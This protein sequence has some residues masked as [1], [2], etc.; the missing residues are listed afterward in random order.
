MLKSRTTP[1]CLIFAVLTVVLLSLSSTALAKTA[2]HGLTPKALT[3]Q[4]VGTL[5]GKAVTIGVPCTETVQESSS[6][7]PVCSL[8]GSRHGHRV[9]VV[10][11]CDVPITPVLTSTH[12]TN[13]GTKGTGI[14][15][16]NCKDK[17]AALV[18]PA[19]GLILCASDDS[20]TCNHN[21][22]LTLTPQGDPT[23]LAIDTS[24]S[25]TQPRCHIPSGT[26]VGPD[27]QSIVCFNGSAIHCPYDGVLG[28]D[29][30]DA[31]YCYPDGTPVETT[32][33]AIIL[34]ASELGT[35]DDG[36]NPGVEGYDD[37]GDPLCSDFS[38]PFVDDNSGD[39]SGSG[40]GDGSGSNP[41]T[42]VC[43]DD[44]TP[45]LG[46]CDDGSAPT[47]E[48]CDDNSTPGDGPSDPNGVATCADDTYPTINGVPIA[49]GSPDPGSFS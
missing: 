16:L 30:H 33:P 42:S 38:N 12:G 8:K 49:A 23:C 13:S 25:S 24:V 28:T 14:S 19:T 17:S 43:E 22:F 35:C 32:A 40:S 7:P 47:D 21:G 44:S 48:V 15:T 10:T 9:T 36:S 20:P 39:G 31:P 5:H 6:T 18:D 27:T 2:K 3:C 1:L 11:A 41:G 26:A 37:S 4:A 34:S 46:L 45:T 29:N